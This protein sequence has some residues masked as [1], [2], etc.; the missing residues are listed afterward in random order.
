MRKKCQYKFVE[1]KNVKIQGMEEGMKY[2]DC[3]CDTLTELKEG[4]TLAQNK[5]NV[6]VGALREA[7]CIIQCSS[8]FIP[9]GTFA[10]NERQE[11]IDTEYQRIV[12]V[13]EREMV[14][15]EAQLI[16]VLNKNDIFKCLEGEKTG[17]LLTIEDGGVFQGDMNRL[18]RAYN[19]GVRLVTLT[20]NH[21]NELGYPNSLSEEVM[22][23]GLKSF[24]YDVIEEM[25]RLGMIIDVS[26]LSD[27]G[28]ANVAE[29]MKKKGLPFIASHSNA[30]ALCAHPRNLTDSQILTLAEAGGIMG[31]N[32]ASHFLNE[33]ESADGES[34]IEDMVRHVLH[35]RNV[36]G[37]DVL[38]I[39]SDFDGVASRLEIDSPVK[40]NLLYEALHKAGM[41]TGELEK[42]FYE[43]AL[44]VFTA[45]F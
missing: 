9:T 25:C 14:Q 35:I 18:Y 32:F 43:N 37:A 12:K 41:T 30:R 6:S 1:L 7:E 24:G 40:M 13:Y 28:F 3:H 2:I 17:I 39:G 33:N 20:W 10:P 44:R 34:R 4:E 23:K 26:H 45:V 21:E 16:R 11:K 8:I 31:L 5:R 42:M 38:A 36:G 19:D 27:G 29:Y 22:S 15:N